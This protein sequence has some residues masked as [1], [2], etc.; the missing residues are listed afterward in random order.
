MDE[1]I[2]S[3]E[4]RLRR[5]RQARKQ[6]ESILTEKSIALYQAL[7]ESEQ[8]KK[9][10]ELALWASQISFWEWRAADDLFEVRSFS[11]TGGKESVSRGNLISLMRLIHDD[12]I[13]NLQFVWA[14][15]VH[16]SRDRI[17]STF[18]FKSG[19]GYQWVR[20]RGRVLER[21]ANNEA[22]H[23]VGITR[24]ITHEVDAEHSFHLLASA[25]SSSRE[26][27]V[28]L[29][30][31]LEITEA[32]E[33]FGRLM[34]VENKDGFIGRQLS[35]Y[36]HDETDVSQLSADEERHVETEITPPFGQPIPIEL[37][38]AR[39]AEEKKRAPYFIATMRDISERKQNEARLRQLA[40]QDDLTGLLNRNGLNDAITR[41]TDKQTA[42]A[43]LFIDLDG[44]KQVNDTAGHEQGDACLKAVAGVLTRIFDRHSTLTRWGGDE[45]VVVM[46]QPAQAVANSDALIDALEHL[47]I[48]TPS[49]DLWLSASIGVAFYPEHGDTP[50]GIIQAAD[51]AMYHAKVSGKGRVQ[52]YER[53]LY[54]KMAEK[55]S[56]ANELRRAIEGQMLDFYIQ[57]KYDLNGQLRG[58]EVLCRWMSGFHGLVP[59]DIFIPIA[60][61][62]NL[63]SQIGCQALEAACD[64]IS[65]MEA[66]GRTIPLA[67]NITVNQLVDPAFPGIARAICDDSQV[68]TGLIEIEL[69]ESAF[70]KEPERAMQALKSLQKLG[71]RLALDDFGAG[72]SAISYLRQFDFDVVKVDRSLVS[73]LDTNTRALALFQGLTAM[74]NSLQVDVV[75]EGVEKASYLPFIIESGVSLLQGFYFDRP[76]PYQQFLGRNNL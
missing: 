30:V 38:I 36:I 41:L 16:G 40:L 39:F 68:S 3:L 6:A 50:S 54:E 15:T 13:E 26:P 28:V 22:L 18:R 67:I 71:F 31:S 66:N 42:F 75:V 65:M 8:A 10:L 48:S 7:Q 43:V 69:T 55:V 49:A 53:G 24:D 45:F 63:D 12:D 70:L 25:F 20:L 29:S 76:M 9:K 72:F 35:D 61:D 11:L 2:S 60:S 73:E 21:G 4:R 52:V 34:G 19:N 59:P 44:F 32:N 56:M 51:A 33:A 5:E 37:S 14:M 74:L 64:Y 27:M 47:D 23:I 17:E 57:G 58:G 46:T 62:N 1:M